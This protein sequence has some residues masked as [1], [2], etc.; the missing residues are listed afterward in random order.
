MPN[1]ADAWQEF[2]VPKLQ[3]AGWGW[4]HKP[5]SIT[6]RTL[7]NGRSVVAGNNNRRRKSKVKVQILKA[8][9]RTVQPWDLFLKQFFLDK[10]FLKQRTEKCL[11]S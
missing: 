10:E 1:E 7:T 6:E 5:H 2:V 8:K 9:D 11:A 3:V 4:D